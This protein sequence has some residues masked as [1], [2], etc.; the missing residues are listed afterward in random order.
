M[1]KNGG[2]GV[3]TPDRRFP[4]SDTPPADAMKRGADKDKMIHGSGVVKK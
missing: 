3:K 4:V 1:N 2:G